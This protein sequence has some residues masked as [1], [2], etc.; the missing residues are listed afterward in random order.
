VIVRFLEDEFE[1]DRGRQKGI[2]RDEKELGER[3]E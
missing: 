1:E 3:I 2:H